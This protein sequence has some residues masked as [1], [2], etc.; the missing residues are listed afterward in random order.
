VDPVTYPAIQ[1]LIGG[2]ALRSYHMRQFAVFGPNQGIQRVTC[3]SLP[4]LAG[5]A[6]PKRDSPRYWQECE[7]LFRRTIAASAR[8][9]LKALSGAFGF[10]AVAR[11]A[12]K[13]RRCLLELHVKALF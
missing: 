3:L 13:R 11:L 12:K 10:S 1:E 4:V 6:S 8:V 9:D 2:R 7:I 5:A